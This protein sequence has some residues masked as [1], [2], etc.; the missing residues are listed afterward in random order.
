MQKSGQE[1]I[2]HHFHWQYLDDIIQPSK[3]LRDASILR[4]LFFATLGYTL[5]L[6]RL[7]GYE[8]GKL[9]ECL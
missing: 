7:N 4:L 6:F 1:V 3:P 9:S 2:V 5:R 8:D